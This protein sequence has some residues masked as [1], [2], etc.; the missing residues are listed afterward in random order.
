LW[1]LDRAKANNILS[2]IKLLLLDR[3]KANNILSHIKLWLLD[4][5]KANNILSPIKLWLF[6]SFESKQY[7]VTYILATSGWVLSVVELVI[8]LII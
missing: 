7:I 8:K 1:L 4:G 3:A 5:S 6:G 2:N